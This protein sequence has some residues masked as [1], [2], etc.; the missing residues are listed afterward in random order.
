MSSL[1]DTKFKLDS[2]DNEAPEF[3]N[4]VTAV[5]NILRNDFSF[6][7]PRA[8]VGNLGYLLCEI[9]NAKVATILNWEI[10][11]WDLI[12]T[13]DIESRY[14]SHLMIWLEWNKVFHSNRVTEWWQI[15]F[16]DKILYL[17]K[18]KI[19]EINEILSYWDFRN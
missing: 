12:F 15:D 9:H 4:C 16:L 13:K 8:Y 7:L 2:Q 11:Y 1:V 3:T 6:E 10:K 17:Q 14:I 5:R 18:R 19:A